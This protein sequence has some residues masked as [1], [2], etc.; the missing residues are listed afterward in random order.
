MEKIKEATSEV[1]LDRALVRLMET[2][3]EDSHGPRR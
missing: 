1:R 2:A 3:R